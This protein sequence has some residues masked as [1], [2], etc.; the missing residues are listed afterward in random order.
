VPGQVEGVFHFGDE[1][2]EG[3]GVSVAG[4]EGAAGDEAGAA[5]ELGAAYSFVI[6]ASSL[7]TQR[8]A[9]PPLDGDPRVFLA[10]PLTDRT[11][12]ATRRFCAEEREAAERKMAA[13]RRSVWLASGER[14]AA[15]RAQPCPVCEVVPPAACDQCGRPR[16]QFHVER[17]DAAMADTAEAEVSRL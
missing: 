14:E 9:E 13:A 12:E 16:K 15:I 8:V 5:D 2:G 17:I 6:E 3:A 11:E 4:G 1:V 10:D 7:Y